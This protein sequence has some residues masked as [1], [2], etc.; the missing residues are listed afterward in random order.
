MTKRDTGLFRFFLKQFRRWNSLREWFAASLDAGM[1]RKTTLYIDLSK[2]A[3]LKD[4]VYWLQILFSAGIATLG[5]VQNSSAVIIGAMLISPL[6]APILSAGLAL[7]TGDLTLGVR[8]IANLFLSTVLGMLFAFLLVELLPFKDQTSE[9]LARTQPNTID[10]VIALFSGAIGAIATCRETKGVVTSIPG[11]A[12]AVALMPPLC[13]VGYGVALG[14]D[15]GWKIAWGGG[16]LYLTNLVAITFTAMLV[17]VLLRLDRKQIRES[18]R[19]W[20][21]GDSE[22]IWWLNLINRVP[23]LEKARKVRSVTLRLLMILIPLIIIYVPL[24]QSFSALKQQFQQQQELNKIRNVAEQFWNDAVAN[25]P[26][27]DLDEIRVSDQGEQLEVYIRAFSNFPFTQ[28]ERA[29]YISRLAGYLRR[30][31]S[32]ISL[33]VIVIPTAQ[34][35]TGGI[36]P[37][38][39]ATPVAVAELNARLIQRYKDALDGF[40][41]TAPAEMIDYSISTRSSGET[42]LTIYYLSS[43][44]IEQD[45]KE[46]LQNSVRGL[47]NL[48]ALALSLSRISSEEVRIP[49]EPGS[50][51]IQNS[52][53]IRDLIATLKEHDDLTVRI[54]LSKPAG[55]VDLL[56]QRKA[57][58][59]DFFFLKNGL[60][61]DRVVFT[62]R[63]A[64][65]NG[66]ER[67]GNGNT[68]QLYL[69]K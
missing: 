5:L 46:A 35:G 69:K 20:R 17:F 63:E 18:V 60:S 16:L 65:E 41:L 9:I 24:S 25:R 55:N 67:V 59:S 38:A 21:E 11:V 22:S 33:Q 64:P 12:I 6:M 3:T 4:L 19:V 45:G 1:E 36:V 62:E 30:E 7:A 2:S 31:P 50:L 44:D 43:R 40:K 42:E 15:S 27:S 37:E 53:E 57:A 58:L 8:A 14:G 32:T 28:E 51:E 13:V 52:D 34:R 26:L 54:M 23:R 66:R 10:L 68:F 47:L 29:Q 39:K 48:N 56:E 49:F 61:R